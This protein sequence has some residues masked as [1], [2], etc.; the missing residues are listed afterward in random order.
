MKS[1]VN[2]DGDGDGLS[3]TKGGTNLLLID[4]R[5]LSLVLVVGA[6]LTSPDLPPLF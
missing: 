4:S 3:E 5:T 2:G 6:Y 1:Y